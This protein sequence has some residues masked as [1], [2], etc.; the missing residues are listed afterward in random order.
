MVRTY[1]KC[2]VSGKKEQIVEE[3]HW[4]DFNQIV[5]HSVVGLGSTGRMGENPIQETFKNWNLQGGHFQKLESAVAIL[6]TQ[7][8]AAPWKEGFQN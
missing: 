5:Q 8:E 1:T 2:M 3:V 4:Q 7:R 6:H